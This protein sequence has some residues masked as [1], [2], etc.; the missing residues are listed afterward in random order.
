MKKHIKNAVEG[1]LERYCRHIE[2][3]ESFDRDRAISLCQEYVLEEC[4]VLCLWPKLECQFEI[5]PNIHNA[6]IEATRE[7]FIMPYFSENLFPLTLRFRN[8]KQL[9]PQKFE[10]LGIT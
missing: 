3:K 8:A 10:S 5:Y 7:R 1:Y 6:A 2:D 9:K 4:A